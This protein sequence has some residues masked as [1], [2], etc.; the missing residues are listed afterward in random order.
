MNA[1]RTGLIHKFIGGVGFRFRLRN[2]LDYWCESAGCVVD[3]HMLQHVRCRLKGRLTNRVHADRVPAVTTYHK[4]AAHNPSGRC[5]HALS[6]R[7]NGGLPGALGQQI[8]TLVTA[9]FRA[10]HDQNRRC[11][12]IRAVMPRDRRQV[13]EGFILCC[14]ASSRVCWSSTPADRTRVNMSSHKSE[15]L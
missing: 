4:S 13:G 3:S 2:I 15:L 8:Q 12:S 9:R 1:E 6:L 14:W 10:L 11:Y 5:V 7:F